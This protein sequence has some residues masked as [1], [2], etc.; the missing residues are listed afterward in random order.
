MV[1]GLVWFF[2]TYLIRVFVNLF[3]EP[4]FNP[5]KHFP[6]VTVA[7]KLLLPFSLVAAPLL[8]ELL[9]PFLGVVLAGLLVGLFFLFL[10]GVAGFLVWELKENW[11]LYRANRPT[12]LRPIQIGHHGETLLRLLKPGFHS[13]TIPKLYARL[14]KAWRNAV[15]S[16]QW[17]PFRKQREA[18]HQVEHAVHSFM[19]R[20]FL[21]LLHGSKNWGGI[22]IQIGKIALGTQRID[23]ELR[24]PELGEAAARVRFSQNAGLLLA[25]VAEPGWIPLL[26]DP[27][28]RALALALA[29]QYK[30]G[31]IHL[32]REQIDFL[33]GSERRAYTLFDRRLMV[34]PEKTETQA[35]AIYDLQQGNRFEPLGE[36]AALPALDASQL[37]LSQTE[38]AWDDWCSAWQQD[39]SGNDLPTALLKNVRFLPEASTGHPSPHLARA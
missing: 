2:V 29:G 32:V 25:Q 27:Q 17:R 33:L 10:P 11:R 20:E 31:G 15:P 9:K 38:I 14:R 35:A 16:G 13:G 18:L 21:A 8:T 22:R 26:S 28:R 30:L 1:L 36:G 23:I 12:M 39:Q 34:W 37:F 7:A 5:I 19:D 6:V 4:T 3:V 24:C